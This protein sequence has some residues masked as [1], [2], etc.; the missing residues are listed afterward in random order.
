MT[1]VLKR[2]TYTISPFHNKDGTGRFAYG[3]N[4]QADVLSTSSNEKMLLRKRKQENEKVIFELD[5]DAPNNNLEYIKKIESHIILKLVTPTIEAKKEAETDSLCTKTSPSTHVIVEHIEGKDGIKQKAKAKNG[6][7]TPSSKEK[8]S[9]KTERDE[10]EKEKNNKKKDKNSSTKR[11]NAERM[12][13]MIDFDNLYVK[14][15]Q[16]EGEK[17]IGMY[18]K[19]LFT[20]DIIMIR[21]RI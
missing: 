21:C 10:T 19:K 9:G 1:T 5:K 7:L 18:N 13:R 16:D 4:K 3:M 6:L 17:R 8:K 12:K 14:D 15:S 2:I 11:L 20:N